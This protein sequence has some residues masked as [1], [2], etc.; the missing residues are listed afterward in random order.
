MTKQYLESRYDY[1][2]GV[3]FAKFNKGKIKIGDALNNNKDKDGY[4]RT[5]VYNKPQRIHRLIFLLHHGYL[6]EVVDHIN[7]D[8]LD[9]RIENLRSSNALLNGNNREK[10][11]NGIPNGVAYH[12]RDKK[13]QVYFQIE[14]KR[15]YLG[16]FNTLEEAKEALRINIC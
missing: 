2:D 13:W 15:K 11:R 6:P 5:S 4:L 10:H 7:G 12:K 3:L 9:N 16:Y 8:R 14:N 1:R